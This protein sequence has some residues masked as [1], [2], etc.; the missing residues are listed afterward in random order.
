[1]TALLDA[2]RDIGVIYKVVGTSATAIL[3]RAMDAPVSIAGER[4][5]PGEIGQFVIV[6]VDSERIFGRI[7]E[8]AATNIDIKSSDARNPLHPALAK[9]D[10][11]G[12][13][14]VAG[15]LTRGIARYPRVGSNVFAA[16]AESVRVALTLDD[17]ALTLGTFVGHGFSVQVSAQSLFGRH[18]AILGATGGGKSWTV[19]QMSEMVASSSGKMV[20]L[21]PT[22]EY[23]TLE[24]AYHLVI[25]EALDEPDSRRVDLP[26]HHFRDS[27]RVAFFDPSGGVQ[28]PKMRAA[29]RL[30][31]LAHKAENHETH[32]VIVQDGIIPEFDSAE[33]V[34]ATTEFRLA[35]ED[36][37]S[38]FNLERLPEQIVA[39]CDKTALNN[40]APL[41]TRM[42]DILQVEEVMKVIRGNTEMDL[43]LEIDEWLARPDQPIL[44]ISLSE[45][46]SAHS[47]RELTVNII[48]AHLLRAA[49]AGA[50]NGCPVVIAIDEAHQFLGAEVDAGQYS[51]RLDAFQ[52]IA[53]EGRKYGLN[54]CVAT[55]R[56]SD[57]PSGFLSQIGTMIVHRVADG[58]DRALVEQA[59]AEMDLNALRFLPGLRQGQAIVMGVDLP[60]P[61]TVA[62]TPPASPPRSAGP[63][64]STDWPFRANL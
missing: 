1:M 59:A 21:D 28:L 57:L 34:A 13:L 33:V 42:R 56:P 46:P 15:R 18:L 3:S 29:V 44:R 40:V 63:S 30:L 55:Q 6:N 19:A 35:M 32:G 7:S 10:L 53:K 22:G 11:L 12:T 49:R 24:D 54:L 64:Y 2:R 38:P 62:I 20:L 16:R 39:I 14:N 5:Y 36:Q 17:T 23:A 61:M 47:L 41:L 50:F 52:R 60:L 8:I 26:H 37:S 45:I 43:I 31:R 25:G 9:I 51:L 58:R 27:D 4:I 48:G